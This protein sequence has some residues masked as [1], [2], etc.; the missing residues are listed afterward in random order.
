MTYALSTAVD[1]GG[2]YMANQAPKTPNANTTMDMTSGS[3]SGF[4]Y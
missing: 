2:V 3:D 1:I 4:R